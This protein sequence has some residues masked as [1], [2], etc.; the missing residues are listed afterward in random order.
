MLVTRPRQRAD[1]LCLALER[2]G[3]TVRSLPLLAISPLRPDADRQ[4]LQDGR[5]LALELDRY[6]RVVCVSVTAVEYGLDWLSG[7]WP[8]WPQG[9]AWY[10][11]GRATAAALAASGLDA[12][13]PGG[14]MNSEALLELPG[15]QQLSGERI[16][17][18]RG[19]GGRDYLAGELTLRGARVDFL[20]CYR[21]GLPAEVDAEALHRAALWADAIGISSGETLANL[22]QL[23]GAAGAAPGDLAATLVVPGQRVE[24]LALAA[25]FRHCLTAENAGVEATVAALTDWWTASGRSMSPPSGDT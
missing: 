3:A 13:E 4:R 23:W 25:G 9:L 15:W 5:N 19:V 2:A 24:A 22:E 6:Q 10:G 16:L 17:I 18:I 21:R 20:E 8:Q 14:A 12:S 1:G 11:V 7:F